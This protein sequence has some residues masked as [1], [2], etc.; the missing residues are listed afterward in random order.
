MVTDPHRLANELFSES[1]LPHTI[2]DK[3]FADKISTTYEKASL[4]L[5]QLEK[6]FREPADDDGDCAIRFNKICNALIKQ[7]DSQ[8]TNLGQN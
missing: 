3:I 6:S 4:L 5:H 2:L 7:G 1:I 8:L